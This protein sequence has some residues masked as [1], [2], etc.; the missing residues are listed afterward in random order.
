[1][2]ERR[3]ITVSSL[4]RYLKGQLESNAVLHGVYVEGE[5]SNMR[6]PYSGHWYFSI[7]DDRSGLPCVMFASANRSVKFPVHDGDKVII[8]GDVTV[9]ESEG[10]MQLIVTGMQ[11]SGMGSLYLQLD[12]LKKK[13]LEEG[14]F[15]DEHKKR[16]PAYPMDIAL[17]TGNNTAARS[18]VLITLQKRWPVAKVTEYPVPVQGNGAASL[19]I[20]GLLK[21]DKDEHDLILL[22]RGGGSIEDLWCFND[23]KLA[24]TIYAMHTPIVTGV[25]HETD[26][27]LVDF[28]S[29]KRAN[30]PTGAVETAVPDIKDVTMMLEGM[31]L[32]MI[33]AMRNKLA[34]VRKDLEQDASCPYLRSPEKIFQ[35]RAY[36]LDRL[37]DCLKVGMMKQQKKKEA[38]ISLQHRLIAAFIQDASFIKAKIRAKEADLIRLFMQRRDA[39]A[40][41]LRMNQ[42]D[43]ER[44]VWQDLDRR[45]TGLEAK[46][47]ILDAY[48][49]LKVMDRGY[50][51][52]MKD[53]HPVHRADELHED[54]IV[55]LRFAQGCADAQII[56]IEQEEQ[57]GSSKEKDI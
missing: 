37:H 30:T 35:E 10:R 21:A 23:E 38:F 15:S 16:L 6:R 49:P 14:L 57:H 8:R 47:H 24:R 39:A 31:K 41:Q 45:R 3:V 40:T 4:V 48:S 25:G 22:V 5:I 36:R 42:K 51:I 27:T 1:M 43:L 52:I 17:V 12:A 54:D 11:P 46:M 20:E 19:I 44:A 33:G 32:R 29:D 18:D 9:Y 56:Q 34:A 2:I 53:G 55:R 26:T 7:K 28:V 50:S 13:L